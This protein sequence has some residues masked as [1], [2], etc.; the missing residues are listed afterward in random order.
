MRRQERKSFGLRVACSF[1]NRRLGLCNPL[2]IFIRIKNKT[3]TWIAQPG[4]VAAVLALE[5]SVLIMKARSSASHE[6]GWYILSVVLTAW[7]MI[8]I[9]AARESKFAKEIA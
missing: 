3:A 7:H 5:K 9:P 6:I 1:A 4:T 8:P 2:A